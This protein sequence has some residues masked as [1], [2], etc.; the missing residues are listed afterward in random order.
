MQATAAAAEADKDDEPAAWSVQPKHAPVGCKSFKENSDGRVD[1]AHVSGAAPCPLAQ[2][3]PAIRYILTEKALDN[4]GADAG[5][6]SFRA[7]MN[8][9]FATR[10]FQKGCI[11]K[12]P[13]YDTLRHRPTR[14]TEQQ[15][16]LRESPLT[17]A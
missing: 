4:R 13:G 5:G 9:V 1:C 17:A 10:R 8:M 15:L 3:G 2:M 6:A 12:L 7:S 14:Q 11:A 16:S